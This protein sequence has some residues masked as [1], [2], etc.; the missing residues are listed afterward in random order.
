MPKATQPHSI[1]NRVP[2][3]FYPPATP[4]KPPKPTR[5]G[6]FGAGA[7]LLTGGAALTTT[8][9]PAPAS[10]DAGIL[11]AY[12]I[13]LLAEADRLRLDGM[14]IG[15]KSNPLDI[16]KDL[17]FVAAVDDMLDR[18]H[19]A[20]DLIH[21]TLART[22]AGLRAKAHAME[23]VLT[24]LVCNH[25][26]ETIADLKQAGEYQDTFALSLARDVLAGVAA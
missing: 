12:Q 6:L 1:A 20:A 23:I 24:N 17:A 7:A 21:D 16:G 9:R 15:S 11:A 4:A 5:R 22:S 25:C 2:P 19:D 14:V 26:G 8:A 18:W 10:A 3:P 13:L